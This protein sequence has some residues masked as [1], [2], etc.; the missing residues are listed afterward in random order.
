MTTNTQK[1]VTEAQSSIAEISKPLRGLDYF[2]FLE[3]IQSHVQ[4]LM[5]CYRDEHREDFE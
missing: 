1:A 5:D 4:C 3:E 2:E